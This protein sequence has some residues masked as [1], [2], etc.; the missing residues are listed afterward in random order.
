MYTSDT[1]ADAPGL[2]DWLWSVAHFQPV[3]FCVMFLDVVQIAWIAYIFVFH[4]YLMCAALTTNEI[5]KSEN[6]DRVYSR[7][8]YNNVVDFFGLPGQRPVDWRRVYSVEDFASQVAMCSSS[9]G[10]TCKDS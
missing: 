7:G 10:R 4:V 6:L 1:A 8:I 2:F 3:L 9:S 5:V